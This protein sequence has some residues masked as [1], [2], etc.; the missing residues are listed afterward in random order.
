VDIKVF[1]RYLRTIGIIT[2]FIIFSSGFVQEAMLVA[3]RF[4]LA[5]WS[6]VPKWKATQNRDLFIGIY[7]LLGLS[8]GLFVLVLAFG[9]AIASYRSSWRLHNQMLDTILH[10]PM[11]F[12]ETTPM[13]RIINRFSKDIN[14]LDYEIPNNLQMFI[15][16][17][18]GIFGIFYVISSST[19]IFIVVFIPILILYIITQVSYWR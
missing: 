13:G 19:P 17:V 5:K 10:C 8:Q 16:N 2:S 14:S 18:M 1:L 4:W 6:S 7:A 15:I 9:I 12:F 11:S 3:S